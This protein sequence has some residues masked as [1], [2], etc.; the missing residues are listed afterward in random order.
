MSVIRER[1]RPRALAI[2]SRGGSRVAQL[3]KRPIPHRAILRVIEHA[4]PRRFDPE[5]ARDL[6]AVFELRVR[7]PRGREPASLALTVADRRCEVSTGPA[8]DSAA[9]AT[10]GADDL[11]RMVSGAVGFPELLASGRLELGGDPFI[12]LRFPG[13]FRLPARPS[14]K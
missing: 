4:I 5:A 8:P 9:T 13:L 2:L 11:I 10:L 6:D 1:G 14:G 7:D 3:D 12:A